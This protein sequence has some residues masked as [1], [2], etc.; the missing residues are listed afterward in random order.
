MVH[1][2]ASQ[3][4]GEVTR[5]QVIDQQ[6]NV[7]PAPISLRLLPPCPVSST[8]TSPTPNIRQGWLSMAQI[9]P[10]AQQTQAHQQA[11][12]EDVYAKA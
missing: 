12:R 5:S 8:L 4:T 11:Q 2:E 1:P 6:C 10:P 3:P 9:C 7:D